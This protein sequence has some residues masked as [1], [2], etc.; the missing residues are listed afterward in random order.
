MPR[1]KASDLK[2]KQFHILK[3]RLVSYI[4]RILHLALDKVNQNS[5]DNH[6][7]MIHEPNKKIPVP[8][9]IINE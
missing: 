3:F 2:T 7:D 6:S 5:S 4:Q 9:H 8:I 1:S